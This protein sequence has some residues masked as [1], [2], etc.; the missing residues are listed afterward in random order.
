MLTFWTPELFKFRRFCFFFYFFFNVKHFS[1]S[2]IKI[3]LWANMKPWYLFAIF[4]I[5]FRVK[6]KT[7][8]FCL[9]GWELSDVQIFLKYPQTTW[10]QRPGQWTGT[11]HVPLSALM[12][13]PAP[14]GTGSGL[15]E[16]GSSGKQRCYQPRTSTDHS[17][18]DTGKDSF[19]LLA[20][21]IMQWNQPRVGMMLA[22][23]RRDRLHSIDQIHCWWFLTWAHPPP[24]I[25]L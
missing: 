5:I 12:A 20:I 9:Q 25:H 8:S 23:E 6:Y 10:Y 3:A 24:T 21:L 13:Y 18:P 4:N 15:R 11:Q 16:G 19:V 17:A 2:C 1:Y 14:T 22:L 7:G